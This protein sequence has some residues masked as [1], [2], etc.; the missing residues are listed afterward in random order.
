MK[1]RFV[2][3]IEQNIV[4]AV[5][6]M[7]GLYGCVLVEE[8]AGAELRAKAKRQSELQESAN[9]QA[10][11]ELRVSANEQAVT[12]VVSR[13]A[14]YRSHTQRLLDTTSG[15]LT[16]CVKLA[17]VN[18][19]E[20]L[21][22][23][24]PDM[25]WG[26]LTGVRPGK[27]GHKL[28]ESG[29]SGEELPRVLE[30]RYL[31]PQKQGR[32]LSNICQ[33]QAKIAPTNEAGLYIGIPFCPTK[34]SYC[35]FPSG[36]IPKS[37]DLQEKF[38]K[39]IELDL[40]N[41]VQLL[42]MHSLRVTSLYIGGGTPTSFSDRVFA[43]F[44]EI[45]REQAPWDFIR[46][47]TVEAGRPDCF[48]RAKLAAMEEVGVNRVSVNP[49]TFHDKTLQR[50]GRH[51]SVKEFYEAY[52]LVRQSRIPIVNMDLI[53]GLPGES[54]QDIVYSLECAAKL[55]PE[56][57]TVH[58]LTLKKDAALFQRQEEVSLSAEAASHMVELGAATAASL[59]MVPYYLYRQHYMLGHLANVGYALPGTESIYNIQMME[60]RHTVM[61]VGP[62]SSSKVPLADGHHLLRHAMPK[63]IAVY[64]KNLTEQFAKRAQL[65]K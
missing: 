26:V 45:V 57:L 44:M 38:L 12:A 54:E 30:K 40:I 20:Q 22:H 2:S 8:Q 33:L 34:C 3:A 55:K 31:I 11:V 62:S 5:R 23:K 17:V 4:P 52:E 32:V 63:N 53:I 64:E 35:S 65:L 27:L 24:R 59:G 48:S 37:E 14:G 7:C 10:E 58:T 19:L 16:R 39:L 9:E 1:I 50:I 51:H 18:V 6:D 61:A 47:F 43:R 46:E 36:I 42:S 28:L 25:P 56:N 13:G 21:T 15:E 41:V 49:Q 60:E 29:I